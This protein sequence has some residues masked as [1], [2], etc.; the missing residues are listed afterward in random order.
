MNY[1]ILAGIYAAMIVGVAFASRGSDEQVDTIA[2]TA[3]VTSLPFLF[4]G[5]LLATMDSA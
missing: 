2:G 4:V 3:F 5:F 1:I